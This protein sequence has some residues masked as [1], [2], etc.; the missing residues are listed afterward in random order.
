MLKFSPYMK[1]TAI[2]WDLNTAYSVEWV[3]V[4]EGLLLC[5]DKRYV[6]VATCSLWKCLATTVRVKVDEMKNIG[7]RSTEVLPMGFPL[8]WLPHLPSAPFLQINISVLSQTQI[9]HWIFK[10]Q[11][12]PITGGAVSWEIIIVPEVECYNWTVSIS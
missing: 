4:I 2:C 1:Q 5:D 12:I 9:A 10:E 3:H 11:H 7:E 6:I 8:V